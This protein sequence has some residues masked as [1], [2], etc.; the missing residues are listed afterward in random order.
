MQAFFFDLDETLIK[1]K[2]I[3]TKLLNETLEEFGYEPFKEEEIKASVGMPLE[4]LLS[5]RAGKDDVERMRKRYVERY[6]DE[7]VKVTKP[8]DG[9]MELLGELRDD[10]TR[11]AI[12]T[13]KSEEEAERVVEHLGLSKY[14]DVVVGHNERWNP[15]PEPDS[16]L[17]ACS[18]LSVSPDRA[19][20]VGDTD[21]D[22]KAGRLAGTFATVG[23]L[24]GVGNKNDL[25]D[26]DYIAKDIEDLKT[27]LKM[28]KNQLG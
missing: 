18:T 1:S 25:K 15:K 14:V 28:I 7:G 16:I 20:M 2:K 23:V 22:I 11:I 10:S 24:W 13:T 6:L 17:K 26:A 27:H 5:L 8:Y 21:V 12:I 4:A 19:V 9:V 3:V